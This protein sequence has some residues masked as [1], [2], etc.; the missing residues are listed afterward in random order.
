MTTMKK[1][2]SNIK[3]CLHLPKS[4]QILATAKYNTIMGIKIKDCEVYGLQF[5]PESISSEYGNIIFG[6]F[7]RLCQTKK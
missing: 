4:I 3:P 6:N 7:I 1:I 2:V 5:H